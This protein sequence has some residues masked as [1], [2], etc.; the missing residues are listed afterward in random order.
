M[1]PDPPGSGMFLLLLADQA[2]IPDQEEVEIPAGNRDRLVC[3]GDDRGGREIAPHG[4]ERN[5]CPE[6][7]H[8][9]RAEMK[10]AGQD[11]VLVITR[12]R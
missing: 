4:I 6:G 3:A 7:R 2:L 8:T 1:H 12:P 11:A 9:R 5:L 10:G